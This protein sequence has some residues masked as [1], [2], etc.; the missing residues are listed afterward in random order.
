MP[1]VPVAGLFDFCFA[2]NGL[3]AL[4]LGV[5]LEGTSFVGWLGEGRYKEMVNWVL[6]DLAGVDCPVKRGTFVEFRNGMINVSPVGRNASDRERREFEVFDGVHKVREGMI[7]RMEE[8]FKGWG[9]KY[10]IGGMI[11]FDVFPVG[12]DKT[13]CLRHLEAVGGRSGVVFEEVHFFGDKA[14]PGGN[15]WELY[16]DKR[17]IGHAVKNPEETMAEVKRLFD[18]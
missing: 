17:T 6:A 3:T 12:W 15:D 7:R 13:F 2:E 4:R 8:R 14:F 1:S 16:E 5:E 10:S 9:L 18:L 11:S